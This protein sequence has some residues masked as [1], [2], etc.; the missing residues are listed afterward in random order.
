MSLGM[1]MQRGAF[2]RLAPRCEQ[3]ACLTLDPAPAPL[4]TDRPSFEPTAATTKPSIR[5]GATRQAAPSGSR[6]CS[7]SLAE[8]RAWLWSSAVDA[9]VLQAVGM[10]REQGAPCHG[11]APPTHTHS[12]QIC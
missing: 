2:D 5:P 3:G 12:Y 9:W 1:P 11:G 6:V 4:A 10:H 7:G 8:C